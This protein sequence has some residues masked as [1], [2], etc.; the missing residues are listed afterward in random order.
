MY[1]I[2]LYRNFIPWSPHNISINEIW[3]LE[4]GAS[5]RHQRGLLPNFYNLAGVGLILEGTLMELAWIKPWSFRRLTRFLVWIIVFLHSWGAVLTSIFH[6][7]HFPLYSNEFSIIINQ[8][9][10]GDDRQHIQSGNTQ[11]LLDL[12]LDLFVYI[13]SWLCWVIKT[14][15]FSPHFSSWTLDVAPAFLILVT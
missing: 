4:L 10:I 5:D 1:F 9:H 13:N 6:S 7:S 2:P 14:A 3:V 11:P 8:G 12:M 15:N